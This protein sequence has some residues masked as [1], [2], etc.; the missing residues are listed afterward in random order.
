MS[1]TA[2]DELFATMTEAKQIDHVPLRVCLVTS[3]VTTS[4]LIELDMNVQAEQLERALA[5]HGMALM[6]NPL[7][8]RQRIVAIPPYL[9]ADAIEQA[10]VIAE[11]GT[12][13][14]PRRDN[15]I[16]EPLHHHTYPR[17]RGVADF[18]RKRNQS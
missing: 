6:T 3:E 7:T 4:T 14:L 10:T 16:V 5:A 8:S 13:H 15:R 17:T 11:R 2:F 9:Q 1:R 12:E 18:N